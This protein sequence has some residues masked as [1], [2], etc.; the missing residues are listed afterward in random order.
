MEA[1]R[2]QLLISLRSP[3]MS[4]P[5]FLA[6]SFPGRGVGA[7]L[8]DVHDAQTRMSVAPNRKD[9]KPSSA[10][11]LLC[12]LEN[13]LNISEPCFPLFGGE[14]KFLHDKTVVKIE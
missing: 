9:S 2:P 5:V 13:L 12:D 6:K 7:S 1:S 11:Y 14:D 4:V 3:S 8:G 10:V